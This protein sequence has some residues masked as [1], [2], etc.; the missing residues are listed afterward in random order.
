MLAIRNPLALAM[1]RVKKAKKSSWKND[2][3]DTNT[4]N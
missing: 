3:G 4:A 2:D 1:G